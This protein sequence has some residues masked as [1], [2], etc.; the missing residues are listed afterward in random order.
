MNHYG[1]VFERKD[2]RDGAKWHGMYDDVAICELLPYFSC[3]EELFREMEKGNII[4]TPRAYYR[5]REKLYVAS[6][7]IA[8][9]MAALCR[10]RGDI[11]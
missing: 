4:Y 1:F 7:T 9:T 10:N 2:R 8:A 5:M 3:V 6:P 11:A